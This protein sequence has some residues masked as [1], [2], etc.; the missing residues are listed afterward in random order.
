MCF[1]KGTVFLKEDIVRGFVMI[2]MFGRVTR[3][4]VIARS[5]SREGVGLRS[6]VPDMRIWISG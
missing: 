5:G 3:F 1:I 6:K 2:W 4:G